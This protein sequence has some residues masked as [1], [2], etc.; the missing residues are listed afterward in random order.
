MLR[1]YYGGMLKWLHF[2]MYKVELVHR[3]YYL[4]RHYMQF[5]LHAFGYK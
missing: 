3:F 5:H 4:K 2:P 1:M